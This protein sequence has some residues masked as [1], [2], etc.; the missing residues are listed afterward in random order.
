[1]EAIFLRDELRQALQLPPVPGELT[2]R[3]VWSLDPP[4]GQVLEQMPAAKHKQ[5]LQSFQQANPDR[6]VDVVIESLNTVSSRLCGEI[7]RLLLQE[8][9]FDRFKEWLSRMISHHQASSD[10]LLWLARD[11][12]DAFADVLGPEV[13]RAMLSSIE[14]DLDAKKSNRLRDFLLDDQEL[15]VQLI[16]AED[17]EGIKDLTRALQLSTSFDDMDKRSLLARIVK[18]FPAMQPM[19]SGEQ[20]ARQ[21]TTLWVSWPSLE[22]RVSEYEELVHKRIPANSKEIA[23]ARSYGDLRENHEYKAA[24]EMQKLLLRRKGEIES[25]MA[26][27]RGTDFANPRTDV[28]SIGTRV[29][30]FD[31][32]TQH[33]EKF[34]ILGAWDF[35]LEAGIVSYLSPMAQALLNHKVSDE[36]TFDIG[37]GARPYRVLSIEAYVT[38]TKAAPPPAESLAALAAQPGAVDAGMAGESAPP[39]VGAPTPEAALPSAETSGQPPSLASESAGTEPTGPTGSPPSTP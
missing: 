25:Q 12:S 18:H 4:V 26:R 31:L 23:V 14:R 22:R 32:Q 13:F 24:K 1:L 2:A 38:S 30:A 34:V 10:L 11:R 28:V 6:W 17:L 20:H 3:E 36:V 15:L 5:A 29:G 8:G 37:H 21:E 27:A 35:D 39:V 33:E 9:H 7:V 16:E 19:I